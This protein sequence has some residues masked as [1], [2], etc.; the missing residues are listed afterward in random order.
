MCGYNAEFLTVHACSNV[1]KLCFIDF[2]M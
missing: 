1:A 2:I